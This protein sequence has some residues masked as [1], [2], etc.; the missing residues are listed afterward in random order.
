MKRFDLIVI[1]T[2][3]AGLTAAR[4][5]V[6]MGAKVLIAGR[7]MGA[8]TLFGNTIDLLG[9]I[10]PETEMAE[11]ITALD[12]G[13]SGTPLRPDGYGRGSKTP[14]PTSGGSSRRPTA[15]PPRGRGT[16]SSPPARGRCVPP[17]LSPSRWPPAPR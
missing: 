6:E 2:G 9:E 7:G 8:L 15:S 13:P 16:P 1:G 10:P 14:S 17:I 3:L 11:G 4:T 5:A 12:R